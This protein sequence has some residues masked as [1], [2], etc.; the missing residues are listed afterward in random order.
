[1]EHITKTKKTQHMKHKNV[2]THHVNSQTVKSINPLHK[3]PDP[4]HLIQLAEEDTPKEDC[5]EI[6]DKDVGYQY[7]TLE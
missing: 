3:R 1:M 5:P 6:S 2:E 4:Y 7:K